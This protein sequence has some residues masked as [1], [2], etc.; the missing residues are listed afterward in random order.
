M[1]YGTGRNK[2]MFIEVAKQKNV[3]FENWEGV[4]RSEL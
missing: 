2:L 4:M 3:A 1:K